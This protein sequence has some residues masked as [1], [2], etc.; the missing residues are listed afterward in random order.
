MPGVQPQIHRFAAAADEDAKRTE[1][2]MTKK[3]KARKRVTTCAQREA[4]APKFTLEEA[5]DHDVSDYVGDPV[6]GTLAVAYL[7][8]SIS[9]TGNDKIDGPIAQGFA[10]VLR[11]YAH[12]VGVYLRPKAADANF[13]ELAS[14]K[15]GD[16]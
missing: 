3:L 12:H 2:D 9:S 7:L 11:H 15:G 8:E 10:C 5:F 4:L 13:L 1:E 6:K 14:A 16:E